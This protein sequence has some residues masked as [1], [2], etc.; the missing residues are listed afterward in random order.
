[1]ALPD[2]ADVWP[3]ESHK[4]AY[5][6]YEL[7]D[8]WYTGSVDALE[9]LYATTRLTQSTGI[10]GQ[11]RRR[12]FGSPNP[13]QQS[14][15]PVKLHV[16]V[17][18]SIARVSASL[19][20][21]EMPSVTLEGASDDAMARIG[22]LLDDGAHAALLE[23]GELASA[24]SGVFLR[25]SWDTDAVPDKPFLTVVAPDG[26]VP[27]FR[28]GRLVAVTFWAD[29]APITGRSGTYRL[30]ER[31]EPGTIEWGLYHSEATGALGRRV[32]LAE[33]PAT[34]YLGTSVNDMAQVETGTQL[35]TAVYIPN[36]RPN[37]S[38]RKDPVASN[39][40]RSDFDGAEDLF[41]ALDEVYTSWM[42]DIRLG[43]ARVLIDREMLTQ[44]K[45]GEG[46]TFNT[47]QEVFTP[48]GGGKPGAVGSGNATPPAPI[49]QVEFKIRVAEHAATAKDLLSRI[50][51]AAGYSPQTFG[52][53]GASAVRTI[54]ATEVDSRD[55]MSM[56]TRG[57]KIL[58]ARPQLQHLVAALLDV[59]AFVFNGPGRGDV[60][61][62]VE[63]PDAAAPSIDAMATTLQLLRAA[64]IIS[65]ETGVRML[66]PDWDDQQVK[67][68]LDALQAAKP[69]PFPDPMFMHPAEGNLNDG[70]TPADGV[71]AVNG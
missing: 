51:D 26:A 37:R 65:D 12:F 50:Y 5:T 38:R 46:A 8:A 27:E 19:M 4:P 10:W 62:G 58:Y 70:G 18:A 71:P 40:G 34:E 44:G 52:E 16:P 25:V 35:L 33:H 57:V 17:A 49:T 47:D 48:L 56:L 7:W 20:Y 36:V 23:G 60:M 45:P 68:E 21:G 24:L 31:H 9:M 67:D 66:H 15:R 42:R 39:L 1:M 30:L 6:D 13:G 55:R 29:L 22:D 53:A 32:P 61:P 11:V 59:D 64:D 69:A 28:F 43:K 3:P 54:T 14:Q 2:R 63:F 41:D